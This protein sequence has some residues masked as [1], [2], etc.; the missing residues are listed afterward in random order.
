[1]WSQRYDYFDFIFTK[2]KKK[3]KNKS[4]TFCPL[5]VMKYFLLLNLPLCTQSKNS[6]WI[7]LLY[8]SKYTYICV[9]ICIYVYTYLL[10]IYNIIDWL[11]HSAGNCMLSISYM[12]ILICVSFFGI[13]FFPFY[14]VVLWIIK[15]LVLLTFLL[16]VIIISFLTL[17]HLIQGDFFIILLCN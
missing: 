7:Y 9:Y 17:Q 15:D 10:Y 12:M 5:P 13:L 14:F 16:E 11:T 6:F 1:M 2:T 4:V 3:N 8:L